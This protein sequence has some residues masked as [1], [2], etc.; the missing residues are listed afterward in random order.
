MPDGGGDAEGEVLGEL[1]GL[2]VV[3]DD[4]LVELEVKLGEGSGEKKQA[5]TA[6]ASAQPGDGG[7]G[8]SEGASDLA[9]GGAGAQ[10]LDVAVQAVFNAVAILFIP[11][12]LM[13]L[14]RKSAIA[15][16]LSY[17]LIVLASWLLGGGDPVTLVLS[18]SIMGIYYFLLLRFG[19]LA[20]AAGLVCQFLLRGMPVTMD[21]STWYA[22]S[23][24]LTLA[25]LLVLAGYGFWTALAGQSLI[26][27]SLM[28]E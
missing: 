21:F 17:A 20:M 3:D 16:G 1:E 24:I 12:L 22:G 13:F 23:T 10:F 7:G 5:V 19:V 25:G 27:G 26:R 28:E 8:A 2:E 9:V 6:E 14:V 4:G 15:F 11:L 18:A